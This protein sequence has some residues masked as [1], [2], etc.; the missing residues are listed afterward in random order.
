MLS[1]MMSNSALYIRQPLHE[2]LSKTNTSLYQNYGN[3]NI[4]V[5]VSSTATVFRGLGNLGGEFRK[6]QLQPI[7]S[8]SQPILHAIDIT[9]GYESN[10][11]MVLK[12]ISFSLQIGKLI[13]ICGRTGCGKSTLT[14]LLVR[15]LNDFEGRLLFNGKL[16][17]ELPL[18]EYRRY[19]QLYPQNS[20]IFS[21]KLRDYL[22]PKGLYSDMK[23]NQIMND[24]S[25]AIKSSHGLRTN[26]SIMGNEINLDVTQSGVDIMQQSMST[27]DDQEEEE[28]IEIGIGEVVMQEITLDFVV[29]AGGSNL[30][31]G[32]KQVN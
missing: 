3:N 16:V 19:I 30:S 26:V 23:L 8:S 24:L 32:Q 1:D 27:T 12:N 22:D 21:G 29:S 11:P 14:L 2:D 10:L 15:A 28:T 31:A 4:G 13:G 9:S 6:Q 17:N 25:G 20:Y 18:V 7:L 5:G